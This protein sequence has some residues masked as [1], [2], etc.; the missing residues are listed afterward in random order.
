MKQTSSSHVVLA[1]GG[2]GELTRKL[3]SERVIPRLANEFLDP[4]TDSA[5]LPA[6]EGEICFTTDSYVVEPLIFPGGDIGRLAICGTVND[7]A[8]MG[9]RPLALSVGLI[10]EEGLP[11]ELLDRV[12]DSMAAAAK[13]AAVPVVTGDTKVIEQRG[14]SGMTITTA[15]VGAMRAGFRPG[16][17]LIEAGDRVIVS[18][19]IAEHGL[20]VM[21]AR[22]SLGIDSLLKS[23]AAPLAGLV[24]TVC[25]ACHTIRFV[26][27]P[28]RG[29]VAGVVADLV[30]DAALGVEIEESALPIAP[31]V[32]HAAELLGL[33]PLTVANEGKI[34]IVVSEEDAER[35]LEACRSHPLGRA[36]TIVGRIVESDPPLAE[37]ITRIGGRL[38]IQRPYGEELPRIC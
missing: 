23:D 26:R 36:A 25:D 21:A 6:V 11:L 31:A 35:A 8:V 17:G 28:T 12:V 18:G 5:V 15:G 9:A 14:G 7:L 20:A 37:L 24:K 33:V 1:H 22:E 29:G 30:D 2:G 34:V 19:L 4:L 13:E 16:A 10:L 38:V 32:R 27:D 3:L